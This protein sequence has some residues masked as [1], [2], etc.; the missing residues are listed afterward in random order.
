MSVMRFDSFRD[1]DRLTQQLLGEG[2]RRSG[3]QGFPMDAYRRG[4]RFYVHLDLPGVDP[5]S[6]D[7]T[8]E[9]NVLT[10]R[11][12][13][14]FQGN[15]GDE[16]IVFERPQGSF[17]RQLFVSEALDTDAIDASYDQG[18]L[19]LEIPVA[20]QAKPKR[21]EI[22]RR[23]SG[24]Q[25]IEGTGRASSETSDAGRAPQPG[26]TPA[27]GEAPRT[28]GVITGRDEDADS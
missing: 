28:S 10:I 2:G 12:E 18:V 13:R 26:V 27:P 9:R 24:R 1:F 3:P 15:Q 4:D 5:D 20:E 6:I 17:S 25:T 19:T 11:A 7:L 14:S 22:S 21:I 23:Q 8:C 16:V